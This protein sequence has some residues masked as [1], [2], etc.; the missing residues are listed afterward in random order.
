MHWPIVICFV[1]ARAVVS[2]GGGYGSRPQM[3]TSDNICL[4]VGV[5]GLSAACRH[6]SLSSPLPLS[7]SLLSQ[8]VFYCTACHRPY[9]ARIAAA[10][11]LSTHIIQCVVL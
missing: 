6:V 8:I 7:V 11:V 4:Y 1:Y 3:Y 5:C 9:Y 2:W 10:D